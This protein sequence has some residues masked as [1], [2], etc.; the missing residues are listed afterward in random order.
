MQPL[1]RGGGRGAGK[2]GPPGGWAVSN[3]CCS[4]SA[5][6]PDWAAA[7]RE[8]VEQVPVQQKAKFSRSRPNVLVDTLE[9]RWSARLR[10]TLRKSFGRSGGSSTRPRSTPTPLP[11]PRYPQTV[12]RTA[13]A[14]CTTAAESSPTPSPPPELAD[15]GLEQRAG[16]AGRRSGSPPTGS[17]PPA[18]EE[19]ALRIPTTR[20]TGANEVGRHP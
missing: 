5:D 12:Q 15:L 7:G 18:T 14:H 11:R 16:V 4:T 17:N 8:L 9:T 2:S 1:W 10:P 19:V 20:S 3:R 6:P 13:R